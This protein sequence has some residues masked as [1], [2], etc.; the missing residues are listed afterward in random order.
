MGERTLPYEGSIFVEVNELGGTVFDATIEAAS[1]S[2]VVDILEALVGSSV[3]TAYCEEEDY[4]EGGEADGYRAWGRVIGHI[5]M[6]ILRG[7]PRE[8]I[9]AVL[10]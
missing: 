2:A 10:R 6:G 4:D 3:T 5:P 7:G 1:D 9:C 8:A